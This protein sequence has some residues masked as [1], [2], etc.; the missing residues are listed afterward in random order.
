MAKQSTDHSGPAFPWQG[1][2]NRFYSGLT[3]RDYFMAHAPMT[4]ETDEDGEVT[5][6]PPWWYEHRELPVL[7]TE[8]LKGKDEP[9][10]RDKVIRANREDIKKWHQERFFMWRIWYAEQM[11]ELRKV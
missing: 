4:R 10:E 9:G 8:D 3:V 11:V 5:E 1:D 7:T 6:A 2:D